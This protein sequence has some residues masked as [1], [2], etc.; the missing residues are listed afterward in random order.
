MVGFLAGEQSLP[1]QQIFIKHLLCVGSGAT[2]KGKK[3]VHRWKETQNGMSL[4]GRQRQNLDHATPWR[5]GIG[6]RV[7]FWE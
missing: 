3:K 4:C 6:F 5:V 1:K 7:F 2:K